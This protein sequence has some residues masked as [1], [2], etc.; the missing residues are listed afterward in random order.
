MQR[1]LARLEADP[2]RWE[3]FLGHEVAACGQPGATD[4]GTHILFAAAQANGEVIV[5]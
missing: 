1:E 3:R 2:A 5:K 4:G